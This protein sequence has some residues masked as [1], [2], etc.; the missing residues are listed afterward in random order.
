[1]LIVWNRTRTRLDA[2]TQVL[3]GPGSNGNEGLLCI[4]QS[5]SIIWASPSDF[6]VSYPGYSLGE[7]YSSAEKQS[8]YSTAPTPQPTG[9]TGVVNTGYTLKNY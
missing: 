9:Q 5:S 1:M 6:L 4:P 2:T 7:S 8:V 3:I